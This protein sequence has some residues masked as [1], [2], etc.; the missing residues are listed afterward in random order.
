MSKIASHVPIPS[1]WLVSLQINASTKAVIPH[2]LNASELKNFIV[3]DVEVMLSCTLDTVS[4]NVG[5]FSRLTILVKSPL[6]HQIT[7]SLNLINVEP[8]GYLMES[9]LR[10][11]VLKGPPL[12]FHSQSRTEECFSIIKHI[13]R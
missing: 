2:A 10:D 11:E 9:H 4:A 5:S 13:S 7:M 3:L 1:V 6:I 8:T 12:R